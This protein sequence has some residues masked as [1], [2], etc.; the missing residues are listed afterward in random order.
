M[1]AGICRSYQ[2][3]T[4][5][6]YMLQQQKWR[7]LPHILLFRYHC[8]L[9][10]LICRPSGSRQHDYNFCMYPHRNNWNWN[11]LFVLLSTWAFQLRMAKTCSSSSCSRER[12]FWSDMNW[13]FPFV[14]G[15]HKSCNFPTDCPRE[16]CCLVFCLH[17]RQASGKRQSGHFGSKK[18]LGSYPSKSPFLESRCIR[19][20]A[21]KEMS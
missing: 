14:A 1:L 21:C 8:L 17:E 20:L 16:R 5:H 2:S 3:I 13:I 15:E 6:L 7:M 19:Q 9:L 12:D 4:D 10:H 18:L 11:N